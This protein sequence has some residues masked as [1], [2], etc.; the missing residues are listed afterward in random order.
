MAEKKFITHYE[1]LKVSRDATD[2]EIIKSYNEILK[3]YNPEIETDEEN[4]KKY[5]KIN[6]IVKISFD[7]LIDPVKRKEHNDLISFIENDDLTKKSEVKNEATIENNQEFRREAAIKN[8][9]NNYKFN[10][11]I[12]KI[13]FL[14]KYHYKNWFNFIKKI[15]FKWDLKSKKVFLVLGLLVFGAIFNL[16]NLVDFVD[17]GDG[18]V[19]S[20]K[21]GLMWQ[22]CSVGQ[23]WKNNTC[24]GIPK[25]I[26]GFD[27]MKYNNI[28]SSDFAGYNDWYVPSEK[29]LISL[30]ECS[31]G[32]EY[33]GLCENER[34][35]LPSINTKYFPNTASI[36]GYWTS[37]DSSGK[38]TIKPNDGK[39]LIGFSNGVVVDFFNWG[40]GHIRLVRSEKKILNN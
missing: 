19:S 31:D 15:Q 5:I 27:V 28:L 25:K 30:I 36:I 33:K 22:R 21:T 3:K 2:E 8:T 7:T 13:K 40:A 38:I 29:E 32:K 4:K 12:N 39:R 1:K 17:N 18:T 14:S 20:K 37:S 10:V 11:L 26:T 34:D 24:E 23:E 16:V 35:N 6:Q 9:S